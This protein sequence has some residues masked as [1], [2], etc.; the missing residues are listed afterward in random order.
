MSEYIITKRGEIMNKKLSIDDLEKTL[1]DIKSQIGSDLPKKHNLEK[2]KNYFYDLITDKNLPEAKD[3]TIFD[4]IIILPTTT[5]HDSGFNIMHFILLDKKYKP[6]AKATLDSDVIT[7]FENPSSGF[8]IDCLPCG[9]L[10][11]F[12]VGSQSKVVFNSWTFL[13]KPYSKL[14]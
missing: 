4:S 11:L 3:G 14:K 9:L 6:I 10:R 8:S 7:D 13:I 2:P 12:H 1:E 5:A